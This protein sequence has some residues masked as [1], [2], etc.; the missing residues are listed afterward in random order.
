[1]A[2]RN[3]AG[4]GGRSP[5]FT[6]NPLQK[7]ATAKVK[8]KPRTAPASSKPSGGSTVSPIIGIPGFGG[9][10]QMS[11]NSNAIKS[12]LG[13]RASASRK[14]PPAAARKIT[15]LSGGGGRSTKKEQ[16]VGTAS[17]GKPGRVSP[18]KRKVQKRNQLN[19][20]NSQMRGPRSNPPEKGSTPGVVSTLAKKINAA[21]KRRGGK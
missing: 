21:R 7:G 2:R 20:M 15:A 1:M 5:S 8:S 10:D 17:T 14:A 16:S 13:G 6:K 4:G 3:D 18:T 9:L 12:A 11:K 19:N